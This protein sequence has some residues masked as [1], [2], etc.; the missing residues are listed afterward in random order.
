LIVFDVKTPMPFRG[1]RDIINSILP[2]DLPRIYSTARIDHAHIFAEI[3][4]LLT[5]NEGIAIDEEDD[6][7]AVAAFFK[8]IGATQCWYGN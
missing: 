4:P 8:K 1:V 7:A 6:T 3:I 5:P 2:P